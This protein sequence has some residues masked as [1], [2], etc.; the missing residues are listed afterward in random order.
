MI[1][2]TCARESSVSVSGVTVS[3]CE[4]DN[5]YMGCVRATNVKFCVLFGCSLIC[6]ISNS[7]ATRM[8]PRLL[9][10]RFPELF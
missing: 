9:V 7:Q 10:V 1:W 8:C 3:F 4:L 6:H 2:E 5:D